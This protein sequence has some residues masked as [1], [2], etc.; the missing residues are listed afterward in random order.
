MWLIIFGIIL[1]VIATIEL[2]AKETEAGS[3]FDYI[4]PLDFFDIKQDKNPTLFWIIIITQYCV[5][6]GLIIEGLREL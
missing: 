1:V 5:G 3:F 2:Y 6:I 4:N